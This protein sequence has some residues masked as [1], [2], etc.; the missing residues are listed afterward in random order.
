MGESRRESWGSELGLVL[1]L[2]GVAVGLGNVWRFPYMLGKFGG[3]NFLVIYI[4]LVLAI[5]VPGLIIEL[6]IARHAR[7]GPF[8]AFA[9]IGVPG[10]KVMG[11]VLLAVA[12]AAVA[13]YIVVIGWVLWYLILS[14]SRVIFIQGTDIATVFTELT[15]SL[16]IQLVMHVSIVVL[17]ML[18]VCGGIRKGIEFASK[19]MMPMVYM[20]L[21]GIVV[22]VLR[23]PRAIDGLVFYLKPEWSSVSGFTVL[24]AM[25]Q[26]FFSLG[27]GSTWIFIYGSYM[28]RGQNIVKNSIYTAIGDTMASFIAGL[29]IL[30]LVFVFGVDPGSGPPL[31][32][33]TLPEIFRLLPGGVLISTLFFTA[34]LFAAILSAV[35]GFEIFVDAMEGYGLSRK[36]AVV[37]MGLI[38]VLLGIPSMLSID[39][40]LYN[41]LFWGSTMLPIA[42]LFSIIAFGWFIDRKI[43]LKELGLEREGMAWKMLYYWVKTVM[44]I[45]VILVLIY[46]WIS[47]F[48]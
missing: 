41:D 28:S 7:R 43:L 16:H 1:S 35:P 9:K 17:C 33:I 25:G 18:I 40:L 30:P 5:G 20:I 8:S 24:A 21:I 42:S 2:L 34:L 48:S 44:P 39:I 38:E 3:A 19:I 4:L 13:Y 12:V 31:M 36:K 32:F 23:L 22:Y 10:G 29:A 46:G 26:V 37:I 45:L 15:N 27:L 14:V 6:T 11:Y 47:W